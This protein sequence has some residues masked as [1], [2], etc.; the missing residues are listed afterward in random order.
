MTKSVSLVNGRKWKSRKAAIDHFKE[1]LAR[2]KDGDR[3]SNSTDHDDLSA[4]LAL[5]DSVVPLGAEKK[6]GTGI[7][8]FSRQRNIGDN[9]ASSGFHVHRT[10]G[11][12]I[13]FSFYDAVRTTK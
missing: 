2:Y 3:I 10:D 8:H 1:M 13:D 5:Y 4:L 12:S 7:A 11:T 9:W 6:S